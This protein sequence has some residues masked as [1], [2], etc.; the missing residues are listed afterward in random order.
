MIEIAKE[1]KRKVYLLLAN[2]TMLIYHRNI[3]RKRRYENDNGD[4]ERTDVIVKV[5]NKWKVNYQRDLAS[6]LAARSLVKHWNASHDT[7]A[8]AQEALRSYWAN[9]NEAREARLSLRSNSRR[10]PS[11]LRFLIF[12]LF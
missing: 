7:K 11:G 4:D 12:V 2:K 10:H 3:D 9:N 8:D 6:G 5:G 1:K